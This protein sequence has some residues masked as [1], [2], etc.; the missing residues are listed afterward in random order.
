MKKYGCIGKK[1]THSFSKEIHAKLADYEYELMEL[2]EEEIAPFFEKKTFAA[3]NVT[4]PYKQTVIPYLDWVSPIA[5]RIGAVNTIVNKEGQLYGY[6]TDYYGMKALIERIGIDVSGKKVLVLGTGGTSKT[7][8]VVAKDLGASKVLTVSRRKTEEYITYEEAILNHADAEVIINTTPSGM[9]PDCGTKP[10]D[11]TPFTQLEGVVDAVYN[12]LR[13][14]LVL[15]AKERGIK[16][17][18]GLYMLVMQAVVAVEKFLDT[19]I[20]KEQADRVF[21]DIFASKENIVLTGMPGSGKSTVGNLLH[22]DGFEFIDI[23]AEVEKRCGC[24]IKEMIQEKGETYFRDLET[25]VIQDVSSQSCRIISTGGGSIL[26]EE[27]VRLLSQNGKLFFLDADLNRLQATASRPLSDTPEKLQ[28]LYAE[29]IDIY[30]S[31]AH[32]IVPD[33]GTA[34][35]EA[36]YIMKK[37]KELI[38]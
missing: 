9:Y 36:S 37:Q 26:R 24:S 4:I 18:C 33:L 25:E 7:A 13:T 32:V 15:D 14:N 12:P 6:N 31:T 22:V 16:A 38:L 21:A 1:L 23:D 2:T 19:S 10:I 27:N 3:I 8:R 17:E 11:I 28:K 35:K 5:S 34:E 29:R 20:P 30:R